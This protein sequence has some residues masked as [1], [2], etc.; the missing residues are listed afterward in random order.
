VERLE[1]FAHDP[2]RGWSPAAE[3]AVGD[4]TYG[5]GATTA[6]AVACAELSRR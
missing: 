3:D 4:R 1:V 6:A 2:L 5:E